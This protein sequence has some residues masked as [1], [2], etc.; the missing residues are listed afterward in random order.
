MIS[1]GGKVNHDPNSAGELVDRFLSA[2]PAAL[3]TITLGG[4]GP[5]GSCQIAV[6]EQ[7]G[8]DTIQELKSVNVLSGSA[9]GYFIYIAFLEGFMRVEN[10]L[11]YDVGVRKLHDASFF[12]G[13]RHFC[14]RRY[15]R[16]SLYENHCVRE[17]VFHLFDPEFANQELRVFSGN[18][19]F[20]SYCSVT[21]QLVKISPTTF[22]DMRVWEVISACLSMTSI[23]GEYA[24]REHRFS[25]PMF[26]PAFRRLIR[27]LIRDSGN[28]LFLNYKKTQV[29][30]N[31]IFLKNQPLRMPVISLIYDFIAFSF[32]FSNSRMVETH[33]QNVALFS[34]KH[35]SSK[36]MQ[37]F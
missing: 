10:Y 35:K 17:T 23:H 11:H 12:R 14:T 3:S 27:T 19:A 5:N 15:K 20:W 16:G 6:L 8:F 9:F 30:K 24:Y 34:D 22:P 29:S 4:T 32:N 2:A 36:D 31:V 26:C 18:V 13:V 37:E 21:Q 33:K 7:L 25:D 28:H 1:R